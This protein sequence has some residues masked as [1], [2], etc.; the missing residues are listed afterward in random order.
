[1]LEKF[2]EAPGYYFLAPNL[3]PIDEAT[4]PVLRPDRGNA[5]R[6]TFT[7]YEDLKALVNDGRELQWLA[8][9]LST[10]VAPLLE[11]RRSLLNIHQVAK[12]PIDIGG[13][14][15]MQSLL[16][17][18]NVGDS[19]TLFKSPF[20]M[21]T[22]AE[23]QW[24][25]IQL[26]CWHGNDPFDAAYRFLRIMRPPRPPRNDFETAFGPISVCIDE[27][28]VALDDDNARAI[29]HSLFKNL[30]LSVAAYL[31][32]TSLEL[33]KSKAFASAIRPQPHVVTCENSYVKNKSAF[34]SHLRLH[35]KDILKELYEF[36]QVRATRASASHGTIPFESRPPLIA[37]GGRRLRFDIN[38]SELWPGLQ[39]WQAI[40][41]TL[42]QWD[43]FKTPNDALISSEHA[44]FLGRIRWTTLFAEELLK[45]S[46]NCN[47]RLSERPDAVRAARDRVADTIKAELKK[48]IC[49]IRDK[50][51]A[52][53]LFETAIRAD[54]NGRSWILPEGDT[55]RYISE[56][57]ALVDQEKTGS[58][59]VRARLR[60]PLV[61]DA[62]MEYLRESKLQEYDKLMED[63]F[64][65]VQVDDKDHGSI[66]KQA[67]YYFV[68]ASIALFLVAKAAILTA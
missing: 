27:A 66:G 52:K 8:D 43:I 3:P 48:Q 18:H 54:V 19:H 12:F 32:G 1:M 36:E 37:R 61:V 33:A 17:T 16:G 30:P 28:Q 25:Q 22:V 49:R 34:W 53:K 63:D 4:D 60:E 15:Q 35:I 57:F 21:A 47:G 42:L 59:A 67:E 41:N 50:E 68:N 13:S 5:S 6:D 14:R 11:A 56:G 20:S 10:F 9:S 29:C 64:S 31:S 7:A 38:F 40:E 45:L 24:M 2:K 46:L 55:A 51:W 39:D 26:C 65:L 62:V 23:I 44:I 58:D